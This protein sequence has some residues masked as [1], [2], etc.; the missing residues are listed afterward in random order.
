MS[1]PTG[2]TERRDRAGK[3]GG[4]K[5]TGAKVAHFAGIEAEKVAKEAAHLAE[6]AAL[7]KEREDALAVITAGTP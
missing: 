3:R 1:K 2:E 6:V 7:T 5:T 4:F